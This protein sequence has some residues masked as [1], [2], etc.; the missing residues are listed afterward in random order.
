MIMIRT[1]GLT[2]LAVA[3][4]ATALAAPPELV[5]T[6]TGTAKIKKFGISG[7]STVK[8]QVELAIG[9]DDSTTLTLNGVQQIT[10]LG[11][12]I[13][14]TADVACLYV[15]PVNPAGSL[16]VVTLSVKKTSLVGTS[17]GL[18]IGPGTPP[19]LI[20]AEEGKWK[21]KKQP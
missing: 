14:N 10:A 9:A 6:Y 8:L 1:I 16:S 12:V 13:A 20:S 19:V 7:K 5:G 21:L 3:L 15:D 2:V 17:T 11:P 4:C 18:A